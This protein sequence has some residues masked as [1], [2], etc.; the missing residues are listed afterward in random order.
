V[1]G[2]SSADISGNGGRGQYEDNGCRQLSGGGDDAAVAGLFKTLRF[3]RQ[4]RREL[5]EWLPEIAYRENVTV[6]DVINRDIIQS[7]LN[8]EKLNA[9]QKSEKIR[10]AL[11][12][13]RFPEFSKLQDRWKKTAAAANPAPSKVRFIPSPGFEKKRLEV[14]L[15]VESPGEAREILESLSKIAP[16][17]WEDL[18]FPR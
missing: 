3:T 6:G 12:K 18:L 15:T 13:T 16:Q 8:S 14:R 11:Y 1:T 9:P 2:E 17:T 4:A 7:I 10:D 5:A